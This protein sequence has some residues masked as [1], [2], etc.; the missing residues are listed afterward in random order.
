MH[1]PAE[2]TAD[3]VSAAVI[4]HAPDDGN[5]CLP[6]DRQLERMPPGI[7]LTI[8]PKANDD[9]TSAGFDGSIA[10]VVHVDPDAF[11]GGVIVDMRGLNQSNL[12]LAIKSSRFPH[13]VFYKLG[14]TPDISGLSYTGG[15]PNA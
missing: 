5:Y 11:N 10:G 2:P 8:I 3:C 13:E 1:T 15:T 7:G 12:D 4:R 6:D 9:G 14:R